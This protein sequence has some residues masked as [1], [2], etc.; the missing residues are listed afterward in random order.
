MRAARLPLTLAV[1]WAAIARGGAAQGVSADSTVVLAGVVVASED[2][3]PLGY[4][5]VSIPALGEIGRERYTSAQGTFAFPGL[6]AGMHRLRVKHLGY[7][8]RDVDVRLAQERT[9]I[10]VELTRIALRLAA[11]RVV[12]REACTHPGPPD[13]TLA[14]ELASLF[15][16][17]RQNAERLR[18]LI[19]RYPYRYFVERSFFNQLRNGESRLVSTDTVGFQSDH[20]WRYRPGRMIS[21]VV[22][23]RRREYVMNLPS[24]VDVVDSAFLANHCFRYAGTDTLSGRTLLRLDFYA[25]KRL[26]E[27]DVDGA[28][29][30]DT[31]TFQIRGARVALTRPPPAL[32]GVQ[33]MTATT[34]F[35]EVFPSIPIPS[36]VTGTTILRSG[37]GP[38]APVSSIE[39]QMLLEVRFLRDLPGSAARPPVPPPGA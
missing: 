33:G 19:E 8:Q 22:E 11:V 1:A 9:E 38:R 32:R 24:L 39:T 3:A 13:S 4:S 7:S 31:T 21:T 27:P 23:G 37:R 35:E 12:A 30:L 36:Y 18:L 34:A 29:Y 25:A 10:R 14:P 5:V 17:V 6:P 26:R 15:E 2:G 20:G 28:V 16:Q